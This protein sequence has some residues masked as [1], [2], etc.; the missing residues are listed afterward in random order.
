MK[1]IFMAGLAAFALSGC[2]TIFEGGTQ[3]VTFKSEPDA[4]SIS[5]TNRAGEKIHAGTT[6]VTLTLKRG[7][8]YFK[9]EVYT[10]RIEKSGY[11]A[12]EITISGGVNGWYFGNILAGGAVG[13]LIVD[14][15]TG[16]MY[17]FRPDI[18]TT[19]LESDGS[20]TSATNGEL[21]ILSTSDVSPEILNQ[22]TPVPQQ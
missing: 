9:S 22:A 3:P 16:A 7:A 11:Q 12:K 4:A 14:P 21:K 17:T 1:A 20:K 6:P 18:V 10:V 2:A 13:M 19:A 5:I 15:I 8:G